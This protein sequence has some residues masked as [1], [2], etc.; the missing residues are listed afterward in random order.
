MANLPNSIPFAT[1]TGWFN[2]A[3]ADTVDVGREPDM[4]PM[5]GV[6]VFTPNIIRV[7]VPGSVPQA[8]TL[9]P[10]SISCTLDADGF[11]SGPDGIK[12]V[13]VV[14]TG[15]LIPSYNVSF[16]LDGVT[17]FSL[18]VVLPADTVTDLTTVLEVP[19]SPGNDIAAWTAVAQ[20]AESAAEAAEESANSIAVDQF[21]KSI[22]GIGPDSEGNVV[23]EGTGGGGGET[24]P[25]GKSAYEIA[26]AAGFSGNV[27]A[28][29]A[30][31]KGATGAAS[32]IP[33]PRGTD[34]TSGTNGQSAYQ[35]AVAAGFVGTSAA[36]LASLKGAKGDKGDTGD[37]GTGGG[38]TAN[39]LLVVSKTGSTWPARPSSSS[40]TVV[41][42]IGADPDPAVVTSGTG[43]MYAG[44]VRIPF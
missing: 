9:F 15:P 14:A 30:S 35:L 7:K 8:M 13:K 33:G 39:A 5:Q 10:K 19:T 18:T 11:L 36:W 31:L 6:V 34:G 40:T 24:G 29:L 38:S 12:D 25:A 42:W 26:V 32:I 28:W 22:N 21:V 27:S 23:V 44:D 41:M 43:G 2:Q 3:V 16:D 1:V 20:R 37:A 17:R 4:V